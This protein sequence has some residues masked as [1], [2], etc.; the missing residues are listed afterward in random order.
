[1]NFPTMKRYILVAIIST[2]MAF[3]LYAQGGSPS[4]NR[5]D[6]VVRSVENGSPYLIPSRSGGDQGQGRQGRDGRDGR[7]GDYRN[8]GG[9]YRDG[10]RGGPSRMRMG[11]RL[12]RHWRSYGGDLSNWSYYGLPAPGRDQRWVRYY[13]DIF[14]VDMVGNILA[15]ASQNGVGYNAPGPYNN[16]YNNSGYYGDGSYGGNGYQ[17]YPDSNGYNSGYYG[18][19]YGYYQTAPNAPVAPQAPPV[20][21]G[22][23]GK[24]QYKTPEGAAVSP[25]TQDDANGWRSEPS[26]Q[27]GVSY[28]EREEYNNYSPQ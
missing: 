13:Q 24:S 12:P 7:D 14:L 16:T 23:Y 18:N 20:G 3:P 22:A 10:G 19:N 9:D 1:M 6:P 25:V 2:G 27:G 28:D 11:G 4:D 8:R 5:G 17:N 26:Q 15:T 21:G